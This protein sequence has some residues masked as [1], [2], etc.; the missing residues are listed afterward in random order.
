MYKEH[1]KE[2]K[3]AYNERIIQVVSTFGGMGQ[4]AES[5]NKSAAT[6]ITRKRNEEYSHVLNLIRTRLRFCLLTSEYLVCVESPYQ[7]SVVQLAWS[8]CE[9]GAS[10]CEEGHDPVFQRR[11]QGD[12]EMATLQE[13]NAVTQGK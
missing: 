6:L 10:V 4:E 9:F 1:E 11:F 13:H 5:F 8:M 3:R 12:N 2:K 7:D